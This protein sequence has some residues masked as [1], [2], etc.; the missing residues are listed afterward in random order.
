MG[1]WLIRAGGHGEFEQYSELPVVLDSVS[2]ALGIETA[3]ATDVLLWVELLDAA[4][5]AN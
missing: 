3:L 5:Q 4:A 2:A 1:L